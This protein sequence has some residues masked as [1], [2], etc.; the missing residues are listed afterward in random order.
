MLARMLGHM[1]NCSCVIIRWM[2]PKLL[3]RADVP[4]NNHDQD[5]RSWYDGTGPKCH[6]T[7]G[8]GPKCHVPRERH[9]VIPSKP[10]TILVPPK[11]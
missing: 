8:P 5:Q 7:M 1:Q 3:V 11:S 4:P 10:T 2:E 9:T 6:G